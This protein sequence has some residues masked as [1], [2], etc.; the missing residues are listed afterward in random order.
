M[1]KFEYET[2]ERTVKETFVKVNYIIC[3]VCG[4]RLDVGE[5]YLDVTTGHHDWGNDSCDSI[6]RRQICGDC[7][8]KVIEEYKEHALNSGRYNTNYIEIEHERVRQYSEPT[9]SNEVAQIFIEREKDK[10]GSYYGDI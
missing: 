3:D 10:D 4:K 9:E 8:D 2:R 1:K 6:D 7:L 5:S